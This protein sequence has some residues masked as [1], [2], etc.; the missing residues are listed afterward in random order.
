MAVAPEM[1]DFVESAGLTAVAY[2]PDSKVI[3]DLHRD[4]WLI[5][6]AAPGKSELGSY[7]ARSHRSPSPVPGGGQQDADVAGRGGRPATYRPESRGHRANVAEYCGIPL[8]TLHI[9]PWRANGRS[10]HSC[11]RRWAAAA[12]KGF[13]WLAWR[14][15]KKVE[16]AQRRELGLPEAR[17]LGHDGSPNVD[18]WSSG[19]RRSALSRAGNRM[20]EMERPAALRRSADLELPTDTDDE[21]ASWI[22]AGTPPICFGFG[23]VG[24]DSAADTLAMISRSARS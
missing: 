7:A 13:E 8:A 17:A 15:P 6:S 24:V 18:R 11:Q 2:G 23:S 10:C 22:A 12:M 9:F 1:V 14:G 19:L 4:F 16:D 3:L 5:S 20:D 21:V